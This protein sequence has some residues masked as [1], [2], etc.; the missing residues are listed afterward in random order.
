MFF[1]RYSVHNKFKYKFKNKI[2]HTITSGSVTVQAIT[3]ATTEDRLLLIVS[4]GACAT[5]A[6]GSLFVLSFRERNSVLELAAA[7]LLAFIQ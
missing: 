5:H 7:F 4:V 3:Y 1:L 2:C 6:H